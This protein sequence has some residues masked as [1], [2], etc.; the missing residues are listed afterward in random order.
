[1][2]VSR[3]AELVFFLGVD[4]LK[5]G[6]YSIGASF[7]LEPTLMVAERCCFYIFPPCRGGK[8]S[9]VVDFSIFGTYNAVPFY[10]YV[11]YMCRLKHSCVLIIIQKLL[12]LCKNNQYV[13][14]YM[15]YTCNQFVYQYYL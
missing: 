10:V 15:K 6:T 9:M 3:S 2:G 13:I 1:M 11:V 4:F 12:I 5:T 14:N 8:R 7:S